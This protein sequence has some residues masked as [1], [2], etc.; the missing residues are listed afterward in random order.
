[1]KNLYKKYIQNLKYCIKRV[2]IFHL[3]LVLVFNSFCYC[4]LR[5]GT[6]F[7]NGQNPLSV[8]KVICQQFLS[9]FTPTYFAV[10]VS[11]SGLKPTLTFTVMHEAFS[12]GSHMVLE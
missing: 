10:A 7:L 3:I 6:G 4:P 5:T 8:T 9:L 2:C 1:M 11:P 12:P